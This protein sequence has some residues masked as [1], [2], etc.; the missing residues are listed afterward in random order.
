VWRRNLYA[1]WLA[2]ILSITGFGFVLPFVPFFIQELGVTEPESVRL[3]TGILSSAPALSMAIMAPVWGL[4]ADRFGKKLMMLRAMAFGAVIMTLMAAARSVEMVLVLRVSQGLFTGTV[5]AAGALVAT[6]TPKERLS[7]ALGFLSSA[8]FIGISVG[9]MVGGLVAEALGYRASFLVGGAMLAAGFLLVLFLVK[10]TNA[11]KVESPLPGPA[12]AVP[13]AQAPATPASPTADSSERPSRRGRLAGLVTLPMLGLFAL[14][15]VLRFV[16]AL[17]IPFLPLYIQE[18]RGQ[19]EGSA[20]ATGLVSAGRGAVTALAALTIVRLGDR[21]SR[22]LLVGILLGLGGI[23]TLPVFFARSLGAFS[24]L[25]ILA[26]FFLGG[27]EPLVQA[28]LSS[29]VDPGRRGLLFG[30]QTSVANMG[31]F[32]APLLGTLVSIRWGLPHIFL[33]L[34]VFLFITATIVT[35]IALRRTREDKNAHR[36]G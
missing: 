36:T 28:D 31:W 21:H 6:G 1:A 23:L 12:E 11:P 20:S 29:R 33:T 30:I 9:P 3:W 24:G 27:V 14:I 25:F 2:Q 5:T 10:E 17:P 8:A 19:L 32:I 22:L 35:G 26:T 13:A 4:L 7:Y 18:L 16:R 15:M 34:A